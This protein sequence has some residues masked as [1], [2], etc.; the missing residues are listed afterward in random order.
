MASKVETKLQQL[1]DEVIE[2]I[3]MDQL[4]QF[5]TS[6]MNQCKPGRACEEEDYFEMITTCALCGK[7]F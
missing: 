2:K 6:G 3:P 7:L 5:E 4:E 1:P